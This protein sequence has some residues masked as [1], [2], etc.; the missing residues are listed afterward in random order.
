[1]TATLQRQDDGRTLV[2]DGLTTLAYDPRYLVAQH[3]GQDVATLTDHV[4]ELAA[5]VSLSWTCSEQP[6]V[7]GVTA[8][9]ERYGEVLGWLREAVGVL[10]TYA[11]DRLLLRDLLLTGWPVSYGLPR[12]MQIQ[13]GLVTARVATVRTVGEAGVVPS[14]A[15]ADV[16]SSRS[17]T[18][19][20]GDVA[21]Q[22]PPQS[23]LAAGLDLAASAVGVR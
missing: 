17:S 22:R 15:R 10:V 21:T 3:P 13:V 7:A 1:M 12:A 16:R 6:A 19:D 8:G 23:A 5:P 4:Q 11:D 2:L 14:R 20:R 18:A 9:P